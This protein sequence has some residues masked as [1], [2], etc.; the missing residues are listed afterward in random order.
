MI[1]VQNMLNI[2]SALINEE[3]MFPSRLHHKMQQNFFLGK[4]KTVL[5]KNAIK[6]ALEQRYLQ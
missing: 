3:P 6:R 5:I 2:I 1:S 4:L